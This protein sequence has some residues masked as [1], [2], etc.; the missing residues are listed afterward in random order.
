MRHL[1]GHRL[2]FLVVCRAQ[3]AALF[4][5]HNIVVGLVAVDEMR[6]PLD[7]VVVVDGCFPFALVGADDVPHLRFKFVANSQF[8]VYDD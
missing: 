1:D 5:K 6:K 3:L 2:A 7:L 4:Y 8:V